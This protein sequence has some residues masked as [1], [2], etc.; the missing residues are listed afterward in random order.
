MQSG[1]SDSSKEPVTK[2]LVERYLLA[3]AY[4][5]APSNGCAYLQWVMEVAESSIGEKD[6]AESRT[7]PATA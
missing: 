2:V 4:I 5:P 7:H 6:H 1:L 3:P